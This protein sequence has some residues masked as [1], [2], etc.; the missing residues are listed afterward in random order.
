VTFPKALLKGDP[1][2]VTVDDE[3]CSYTS[4]ENATHSSIQFTCTYQN[5]FQAAIKGT[6]VIPEF[7]SFPLLPLFMTATLLAAIIYRKHIK[8]KH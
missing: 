4:S 3:V 7:P 2:T 5:T 6:W 1:W 8:P